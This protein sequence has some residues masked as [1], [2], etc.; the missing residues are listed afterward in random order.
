[1]MTLAARILTITTGATA[2][3]IMIGSI[4][5]EVDKKIASSVPTVITCPA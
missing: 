5:S 3:E 4:S 1:M 2:S